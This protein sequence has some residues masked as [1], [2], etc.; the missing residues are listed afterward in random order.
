MR[1]TPRPRET[2][3]DTRPGPP[4]LRSGRALAHTTGVSNSGSPHRSDGRP[5][6]TPRGVRR[7]GPVGRPGTTPPVP[8]RPT[9][10]FLLLLSLGLPGLLFALITWQVVADG[11]LV[12]A[13]ERL[14]AALARPDRI[15][16]LLSDLGNVQVAL[17][18]LAAA[19]ACAAWHGRSSGAD[20]WWLPPAAG[21][22]A[23]AMVPLLV[24]PLKAWTARPGTPVVPPAVGYFPSGH[25]ATAVVAY[26]GAV[27]LLLPWLGPAVARRALLTAGAVLVLGVSFGLVRRGYHWPLDVVASWCLGTVLLV[28]LRWAVHAGGRHRPRRTPSSR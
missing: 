7:S 21:A 12:R 24:A 20:R 27:L 18:V 28:C 2:V 22:L 5:P 1:D 8:R 3:G 17:P 6:Q 11:P 23:M 9:A 16:E 10:P 14:S 25:T 15:S 26:G 19:L 13:D 4:Q